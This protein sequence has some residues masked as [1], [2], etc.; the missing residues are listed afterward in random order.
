MTHPTKHPT[1][2]GLKVFLNAVKSE[3][4]DQGNRNKS[5]PNLPPDE[6]D[7]LAELIKLQ[8]D[9][10][11]TI[12]PCDKGAGVIILDYEDYME[13]CYTHLESHQTQPDGTT[14]PYYKEVKEEALENIKTKILT[15]L[16]E[17]LE[18][19]YISKEEFNA[20]DPSD[21]G[22]AK[23][24]ELFKVH[25]EHEAGTTPPERPIISG[26]GSV[27]ENISLFVDHHI[28]EL[29]NKHPSFLQDTPDFLRSLEE[30]NKELIPDN[31]ILVTIDVSGLYTNIQ[32]EEGLEAVKEALEENKDLEIPAEFI[33]QL[34]DLVL[35]CNV[36][37]FNSE[38]F[39]QIIGT[40]MGTRAAPSYA[41]LFLARKIDPK[42][43]ELA[44]FLANGTNPISFFKR[45]LDDIFMVYNGSVESLHVFLT[46]LN[47][48]HPTI[49][50]TMSH[51]VPNLNEN[52]QQCECEHSPSVAFLDTSCRISN[53]KIIVDLYRKKTDRN[54]YLLT[55]SCHPA[56]VTKNIP[57]SLALR[58]VR[59]C[60]LP[61]DRDKRL[62]ELKCLLL[63]RNY[64]PKLIDA[65]IQKIKEQC[66]QSLLTPD[67]HQ[68]LE[69]FRN[70]GGLW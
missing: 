48:L 20:M 4:E 69:L 68:Y 16:D 32:Q 36:F 22:P 66:L 39:L 25:K 61:G 35:K 49:K 59:I 26:S 45:F 11:I 62:D 12:K 37:E 23:F 21:M 33:L 53:G 55:S 7:A 44:T 9:R 1:P 54:Q 67:C 34:L 64:K 10:V 42:I 2:A 19:E 52:H 56:H 47:K 38:L 43:L 13:S 29:A 51:T 8:K 70:T 50:F 27:T 18:K 15:A 60:T 14:K 24:Y 6:L 40:A 65:A 3:I 58:I 41:N 17:G 63:A 28:K 46:E 31:A 5:R 30:L 57:Y